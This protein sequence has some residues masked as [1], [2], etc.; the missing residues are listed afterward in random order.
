MTSI[1]EGQLPKTNPFPVK[2]KGPHLASRCTHIIYPG[3][4]PKT[5][6]KKTSGSNFHKKNK[7]KKLSNLQKLIQ[8]SG[9]RWGVLLVVSFLWDP[10]THRSGQFIINP[11]PNVF[12]Q[13]GGTL[14]LLFTTIW[15]GI[16]MEGGFVNVAIFLP[17]SSWMDGS[18]F[19]PSI[20]STSIALR[21]EWP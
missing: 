16:P 6:Q 12:G 10:S 8:K 1:F 2:N 17:F 20:A 7:N 5:N 19:W 13:F 14:P 15:G 18:V 21:R 9:K 3:S 11:L 4:S